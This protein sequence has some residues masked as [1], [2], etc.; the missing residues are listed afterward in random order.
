[1][2]RPNLT[3]AWPLNVLQLVQLT[4]ANERVSRRIDAKEISASK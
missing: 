2:M 1:M 3:R 4:K